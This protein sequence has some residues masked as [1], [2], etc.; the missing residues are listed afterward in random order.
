M[1]YDS[2]RSTLSFKENSLSFFFLQLPRAPKKR[3]K[4][5]TQRDRK[6]ESEK[7][8]RERE[9]ESPM[10]LLVVLRDLYRRLFVASSKPNLS[11][12]SQGAAALVKRKAELQKQLEELRASVRK[13]QEDF[14]EDAMIAELRE[15]R[16]VLSQQTEFIQEMRERNKQMLEFTGKAESREQKLQKVREEISKLERDFSPVQE[17]KENEKNPESK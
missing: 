12:S 4:R 10:R 1:K 15:S 3:E 6:S 9:R 11:G 7:R 17:T 16:R 13:S 8:E 2:Y 14:D 5:Q